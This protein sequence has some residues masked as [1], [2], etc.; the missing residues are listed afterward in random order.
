MKITL[1]TPV[2]VQKAMCQAARGLDFSEFER[3]LQ[4]DIRPDQKTLEVMLGVIRSLPFDPKNPIFKAYLETSP[5]YR[6]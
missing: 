6:P 4:Y 3:L 5:N 2:D 1:T